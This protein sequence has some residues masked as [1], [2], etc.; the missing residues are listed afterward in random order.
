MVVVVVVEVTVVEVWVVV[1]VVLVSQFAPSNP[2]L[3]EH[4]QLPVTPVADP[5]F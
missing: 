4:P 3:Q 5:P 2:L 1:V